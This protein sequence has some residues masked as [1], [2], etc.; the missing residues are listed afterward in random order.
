MAGVQRINAA[1]PPGTMPSSTAARKWR[2]S[3]FDAG[4]LFLHL[5]L[6]GGADV[7]DGNAADEFRQALLQFLA[8]VVADVVSSICARSCFTR[9]SMS[10][11]LAGAFDDGGVV[12]VDR[13]RSWRGRGL[14]TL[15]SLELDAE[16]FGDAL[17]A[18]E[19]GDVFEHRL[20]GDRRSPGPSRRDVQRAAQLVHHEGRERFA[21][22]IL[23]DDEQRLA[24]LGDLLEDGQQVLH[25]S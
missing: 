18:G 21:F 2:P 12:L 1:P 13:R 17:A 10:A 8:V 4:L 25:A 16:V 9:P 20:C 7:D 14:Q 24:D 19:D 15:M 5:G 22:D 11:L 3:V 23:R 6:G